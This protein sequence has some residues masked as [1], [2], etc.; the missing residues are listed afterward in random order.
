MGFYDAVGTEPGSPL[1]FADNVPIY[2]ANPGVSSLLNLSREFLLSGDH[3]SLGIAFPPAINTL[4]PSRGTFSG[5]ITVPALSY[6]L[7]ISGDTYVPIGQQPDDNMG[8]MVRIYDKGAKM[9]SVVNAQFILASLIAGNGRTTTQSPGK[10]PY[11]L[12]DPFV[13]LKPGT[14]QM[15]VTNLSPTQDKHIQ[16]LMWLAV[17]VNSSSVNKNIVEG[18]VT[19]G[20]LER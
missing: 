18:G 4:V 19:Q 16:M 6:V 2:T 9:E 1:E 5:V 3:F 14:L 17:P 11:Y 7:N 12:I 13:L 20:S 8:F 10:G 15:E